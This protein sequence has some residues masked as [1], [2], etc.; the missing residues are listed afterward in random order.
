MTDVM[1]AA[2]EHRFRLRVYF[3]DTDAQGVVYHANYL[4]FAERARTEF[5]RSVGLCQ[6]ALRRREGLGFA[7][8]RCTIEYR[9]PARLDDLLEVRTVLGRVS[10]ARVHAVQSVHACRDGAVQEPWLVRL[11][12]HL[13]CVNRSGRPV[14]LPGRMIDAFAVVAAD[15]SRGE[16]EG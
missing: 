2:P 8:T 11:D 13:A 6:E 10:G 9:A 14:R 5:L 12:V 16:M 3:E 4:N 7:V 1:E 15:R